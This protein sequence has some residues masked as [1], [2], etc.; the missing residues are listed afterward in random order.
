M[1]RDTW[2]LRYDALGFRGVIRVVI[3]EQNDIT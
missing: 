1:I 3:Y 2:I